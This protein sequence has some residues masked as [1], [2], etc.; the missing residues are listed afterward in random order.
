MSP[1]RDPAPTRGSDAAGSVSGPPAITP[2]EAEHARDADAQEHQAGGLRDEDVVDQES[3]GLTHKR[4]DVHGSESDRVGSCRCGHERCKQRIGD[5]KANPVP[6]GAEES[7]GLVTL[8]SVLAVLIPGPD[9]E[10]NPK[11]LRR[12][13]GPGDSLVRESASN[14]IWSPAA[15]E[16]V[17]LIAEPSM[18]GPLPRPDR[19]PAESPRKDS[20]PAAGVEPVPVVRS[21]GTSP[22]SGRSRWLLSGC[23]R[24]R[25][26][27][28][29]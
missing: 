13:V 28:N 29:R 23:L 26:W 20:R 16:R 19:V 10:K 24:C 17:C 14:E 2:A 11:S 27:T 8:A 6:G 1:R 3:G 18:T 21:P 4:P 25:L 12:F 7:P 5:W 9:S 22:G 15:R